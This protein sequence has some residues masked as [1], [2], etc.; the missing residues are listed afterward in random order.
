ML[1]NHAFCLLYPS[2][3]EGFGIPLVEAMKCGCPVV[4][5]NTSSIPEVLG[6]AG[7]MV[8]HIDEHAFVQKIKSLENTAFRG[9]N[10]E[11]GYRQARR[12][13]WDTCCQETLAFYGQT[14]KKKFDTITMKTK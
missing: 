6:G 9:E 12:F 7:L 1:Y 3:Y 10:I 5:T 11:K 8:D 14:Y 13:S 2:S 4:T